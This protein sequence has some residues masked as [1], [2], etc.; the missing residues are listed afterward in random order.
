MRINWA[1]V[2]NGL[3]R[4]IRNHPYKIVAASL[5]LAA[6]SL[7]YTRG[8]LEFWT[9]RN[10]LISQK[11]HSA[12]LYREYRKEF[13]DDYLILV[14]Q[15]KDLE[16]AKRFASELGKRMEADQETIQ[17]VFYRIP[18]ETFRRQALLFLEPQEI[19]DLHAKIAKHHDLLE[20]LASSPGLLTLLRTVNE[21]IS[22]ALVRTAVS[23]LFS[24]K[25]EEKEKGKVDPEDLRLMSSLMDSLYTW[26]TDAPRYRSP[27]GVFMQE[28]GGMSD[29][30]YLVDEDRGWLFMMA[31]LRDLQGSFNMEGA[32]IARIREHIHEVSA[33][34]PGVR[35]AITGTPALNSDEM[36]TSLQDMTRAMGL[37]LLL[38][39]GL[40]GQTRRPLAA[41]LA[42]LLGIVWAL[43]WLSLTIGH[44]TILSM[45]F[46]SILVGL[47]IDFGIHLVARYEKERNSGE[48]PP[49]ALGKTLQRVGRA[50]LSGAVT[51]AAAF[52]AL[53]FSS[54]RGI[55]E[56]GWI[57][58][59]GILF[60][61]VAEL[62]F[63]PVLLLWLDRRRTGRQRA[64]GRVRTS[65]GDPRLE[66]IVGWPARH[67]RWVVTVAGCLAVAAVLPWGKVRFDYN[68]LHLQPKGTEAVEWE[69]KLLEAEGNSSAFAAVLVD[70]LEEAREKTREFEGL[71]LVSKVESLASYAPTDPQ[72][73][74]DRILELKPLFEGIELKTEPPSPPSPERAK[75]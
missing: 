31:Y 45:A 27:W 2:A 54:F 22:R 69:L 51:T 18:M 72:E 53:G 33:Q 41:M 59:W 23:G 11:S 68:L 60:C 25:D 73:R 24:E 40:F 75:R 48:D 3:L 50:I 6:L 39:T 67:P 55:K 57:A 71:P 58:G 47:G 19:E 43:G 62:V 34:V 61:L 8:H 7:Q 10:V 32:A 13:K 38:V 44:L 1:G 42:L 52:F 16:Q 63:L 66:R 64:D 26:L 37:A 70:S 4:L 17:E 49:A 9:E 56:F 46:G 65:T 15:S 28:S 20:R 29:D 35:V 30:G 74:M 12:M 5:C 21:Q 36:A 14:L